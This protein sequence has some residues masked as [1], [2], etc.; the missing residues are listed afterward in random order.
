MLAFEISVNGT[1]V[2]VAGAGPKHRVISS[3]VSWTRRDPDQISLH[4]GGVPQSDQHLTWNTPKI[5]I[6]D[7]ITIR[8][9]ETDTVDEPDDIR[10][11]LENL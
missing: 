2:C 8:I 7:E 4:V 11:E 1:I 6:G 5:S 3:I 9:V 10:P